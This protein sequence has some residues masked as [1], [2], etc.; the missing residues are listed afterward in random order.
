MEFISAQEVAEKWNLTKRRVQ[1]LC[2]ENRISG[3]QR[4]GNMWVIPMD[5]QKP[6]DRRS[7]RYNN[8][9]V[10][11]MN[12]QLNIFDSHNRLNASNLEKPAILRD[13]P[14][15]KIY[16]A[17][18]KEASRKKPVFFIHKYFA[19]RITANFRMILLGLTLPYESDIWENFY[20]SF[21]EGIDGNITVLDP[22]MG[23]G[24]ILFEAL[25]LKCNVIGNDLQPLSNFVT[26]ALVSPI[27]EKK[28]KKY[29][30]EFDSSV[31]KNIMKYYTTT[32]PECG[33]DAD[34][35][36]NFHVKKVR[37]K[38]QC[39]EHKLYSGFVIAL[40]KDTFT[41]VCPV[42]NEVF[43]S[44]FKDGYAECSCGHKII[45]PKDGYVERGVFTCPD[46]NESKLLSEFQLEDGYPLETE[47]IAQEY[48]CNHCK[49]HDYKKA[50][51]FDKQLYKEAT[52]EYERIKDTLPIPYQMIPNGYNTNQIL[53]HGYNSFKD[54]FNKR[55]LL[56][57]GMLLKEIN[58]IQDNDAKLWF[59]LAF[60]G[61]LEMN[62]MFCR[63]QHNASKISNIFF[64]HAYVPISM[65]VENNVWGTKLGTGNF[66]KTIEKILRGKKFNTNI[67]DIF[68]NKSGDK[69]DSIQIDSREKV[70][71][72]PVDSFEKLGFD[73]PVIT[74][75]DSRKLEHIPDKSV[76]V[77]LTDPPFGANVMYSELID[78]FHTWNH[79][80]NIGKELGFES[81]LS[82]K[83]EEIIVF[84][85]N[86]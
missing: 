80:S 71:A 30:K 85:R 72:F 84:K 8:N 9:E 49:S 4:I 14:F 77:V 19:R 78:F 22:F 79:M 26:R 29:L 66:T 58:G 27:D 39:K 1:I 68:V 21:E 7:R 69:T 43:Q 11:I 57:L 45:N 70:V 82:P 20:N 55:Q 62:N 18:R 81:P 40:K 59:Q 28:V 53:N 83:S 36:Y 2:S 47:I 75:K 5:A 35:M 61:M 56:T 64:N 48:Y 54:L 46:C 63:Y 37:T 10:K 12:D 73:T 86:H 32:C 23:G 15:E 17:A 38:T 13:L 24:T 74:C 6:I 3:A 16:H 31:G 42:C 33:K 60:S 44:T 65:P 67:Y 51:D 76:D 41:L 25:R 50:D 52:E 34:V